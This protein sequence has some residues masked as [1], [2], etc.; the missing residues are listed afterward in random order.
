MGH[1]RILD[2]S[3]ESEVAVMASGELLV[4]LTPH[5]VT[6]TC[7][8]SDGPTERADGASL[9]RVS[10]SGR[11]ARVDD[12]AAAIGSELLATR[13]GM[14]RVTHL[15]RDGR[16]VDLPD[17]RPGTRYLVSRL[18]ALAAHDRAD[19]V[20]PLGEIRD[21]NKQIVGALGLG[22]FVPDGGSSAASPKQPGRARLA[23]RPADRQWLLSALFAAAT[24]FLG[25]AVGT[26]PGA[27]DEARGSHGS[28]STW[29]MW[30][31]AGFG[32]AG[33]VLLVIATWRWVRAGR[34][35]RLR[36]TAYVILE[37]TPDWRLENKDA[38]LAE[39]RAGFDEMLEVLGPSGLGFDWDWR[40]DERTAPQWDRRVDELVSSFLAVQKNDNH[41]TPNAVFIWAPWPVAMALG[42]RTSARERNAP[43]HV[44]QR[45]SNAPVR[46]RPKLTNA[47]HD[48]LG[49]EDVPSLGSVAPAL[50]VDRSDGKVTV[51][52]KPLGTPQRTR[53]KRGRADSHPA[54]VRDKP[55][56]LLLLV[57]RITHGPVGPIDMDLDKT[58]PFDLEVAP[59]LAER[60]PASGPHQIPVAEWRLEMR[61]AEA[62]TAPVELPWA[63]FPSA[64][65]EI[66]R[67]VAE[68][69]AAHQAKVVL[70]A[71]RMPQ[72]IGVGLGI[73][74]R[75]RSW[76]LATGHRWPEHAYPAIHA[77]DNR[78]LI[79]PDLR[80]GADS[81]PSRRV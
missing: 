62:G 9:V 13:S 47:A 49:T 79:V 41:D 27:L 29:S 74:L 50:A 78:R 22:S 46:A 37:E 14:F 17:V 57:V 40:A 80:L 76:D 33:I 53:R 61:N 65:A 25:A 58:E 66:A 68:Q 31:T 6:L 43:L 72:E 71:T 34:I 32:A 20:F 16:L 73:Q 11:F 77:G 35:R 4:N 10:R 55:Y 3:V 42:A 51:T 69:A 56:S 52:V 21:D 59:S 26:L 1:R 18:T 2:E 67:W 54:T 75:Q 39:V 30:L 12:D 81:V 63:A 5:D 19:L 23:G 38:V 45:P 7:Q 15:R 24:L 28:L 8:T 44:R 60:L 70:L 36:G 64:A 48:F